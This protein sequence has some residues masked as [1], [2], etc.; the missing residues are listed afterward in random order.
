M[1]TQVY[2]GVTG[3]DT[4]EIGIQSAEPGLSGSMKDSGVIDV[5]TVSVP[6]P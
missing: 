2:T 1:Q 4:S 6:L 3:A 5:P